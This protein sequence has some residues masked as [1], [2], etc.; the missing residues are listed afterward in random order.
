MNGW[1]GGWW[2]EGRKEGMMDRW[3]GE[4]KDGYMHA[5]MLE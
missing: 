4:Q 2:L 3:K 5:W 1:M